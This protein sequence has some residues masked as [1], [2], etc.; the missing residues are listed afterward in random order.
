MRLQNTC[1]SVQGLGATLL[2]QFLE[3]RLEMQQVQMSVLLLGICAHK[4]YPLWSQNQVRVFLLSSS[5]P[6]AWAMDN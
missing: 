2:F 6:R 5:W 3:Q 1:G 4:Y